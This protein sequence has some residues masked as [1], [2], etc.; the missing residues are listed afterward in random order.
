MKHKKN[1][2]KKIKKKQSKQDPVVA[3]A[4]PAIPIFKYLIKTIS[5]TIFPTDGII[6][7]YIANFGFPSA[8]ITLLPIMDKAKK[9]TP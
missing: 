8:R 7:A 6:K 9:G 5:K 3:Q 2:N 4:A 1:I